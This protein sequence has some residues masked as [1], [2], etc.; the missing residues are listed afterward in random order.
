VSCNLVSVAIRDTHLTYEYIAKGME[1]SMKSGLFTFDVFP[2]GSPGRE[3]MIDTVLESPEHQLEGNL[4]TNF[5]R[6]GASTAKVA[7][8][9]TSVS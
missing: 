5:S 4:V 8:S 2:W 1:A 7:Q 9:V 3:R 6:A